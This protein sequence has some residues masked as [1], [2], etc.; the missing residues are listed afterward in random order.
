MK[1]MKLCA[2][3]ALLSPFT[4]SAT[5]VYIGAG[6]GYLLDLEEAYFTSRFGFNVA[7][8]ENVS[9]NIELEGGY[10]TT[11]FE[12]SGLL[13]ADDYRLTILPLTLNYRYVLAVNDELST[14]LG[15]GLG[16]ARLSLSQSGD[17]ERKWKFAAQAIAGASYRM[18]SN[19]FL[20]VTARYLHIDHDVPSML[21]FGNDDI[22]I[23]VSASVVF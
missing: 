23:E 7:Q 5:P 10:A 20:G 8:T 14:F 18:S 13:G 1:L 6:A 19:F 16:S 22:S 17:S 3:I 21:D 11:T 2:L 12:G 15:G 4:L 9:H